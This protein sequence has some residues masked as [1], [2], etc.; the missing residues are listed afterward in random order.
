MPGVGCDLDIASLGMLVRA[1]EGKR[2]FTFTHKPLSTD[3][4]R[5]AVRAAN[6]SGFTVNLSANSLSDADRLVGLRVGPVA[7]VLPHDA[8]CK[9]RT[10]QGHPVVVCPN[11]TDGLT[12]LECKLCAKPQRKAIVGFRA[13]G[14][15]KQQVT[16]LVTCP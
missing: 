7:V 11:Q 1:N 2:G 13:H 8:P 6:D 10:P 16:E 15:S 3:A 12:C 5:V 9:V 14:C 4:E